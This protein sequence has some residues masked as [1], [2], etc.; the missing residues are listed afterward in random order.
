MVGCARPAASCLH[1]HLLPALATGRSTGTG[2]LWPHSP[3]PCLPASAA[4]S[5]V[6]TAS[7]GG[8][9]TLPRD[10]TTGGTSRHKKALAQVLHS[11]DSP[12][13]PVSPFPQDQDSWVPNFAATTTI[14]LRCRWLRPLPMGEGPRAGFVPHQE[15][16]LK[17][18]LRFPHL[19]SLR[20][21][22]HTTKPLTDGH[23]GCK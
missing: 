17:P 2:Q 21:L 22:P 5:A 16:A 8:L 15:A 18:H 10:I 6:G 7:Y 14:H 23:H 19:Q 3:P 13:D 4:A 1:P 20:G 12:P 11:P 9:G